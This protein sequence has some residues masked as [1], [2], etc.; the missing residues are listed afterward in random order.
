MK[1]TDALKI[2]NKGKTKW[3]FPRKGSVDHGKVLKIQ[4]KPVVKVKNAVKKVSK[5]K[6]DVKKIDK[7]VE[8]LK[9]ISKKPKSISNKVFIKDVVKAESKTPEFVKVSRNSISKKNSKA[10]RI[11][12]F[13]KNKLITNK[14]TLDNRV[15]FSK[16]LQSRL[17]SINNTDCLDSKIFK[18][19]KKGY[20]IKNIIDLVKQIGTKS[21]Y[22]LIYLSNIK[23]SLGGFSIVSKV[24]APTRDNLQEIK[25]MRK[26][27]D[28]L[29]L[30]KKTKH[31]AIVHKHAVCKRNSLVN[32]DGNKIIMPNQFKLVSINELAH[33]DLKTLIFDRKVA[34]NDELMLN[35]LYQVFISIATFQNIVGYVHNDA[36]YGNF[37]YQINNEKGYYEYEFNGKKYYLKAC[38]YNMI[39]YD[40]GL[41]KDIDTLA[42][43]K[44]HENKIIIDYCRIINAFLTKT[45]GWGEYYDAPTKKC[46]SK[47]QLIQKKLMDIIYKIE[48]VK[49]TP[50]DIFK[51]ILNDALIPFAPL[52]MFME[53]KP[54]NATI[55]NKTPYKID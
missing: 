14:Y 37:L 44:Q 39:I 55:I 21:V 17:K 48:Q 46:E 1:Y 43:L 8:V 32:Y 41:S 45:Y 42:K 53:N 10:K 27:T 50:K 6:K 36:H 18:D 31:F 2:Y 35:I 47:V 5:T 12:R 28:K 25:L 33:G 4:G 38:G 40:F 49:K 34:L 3:C 24:M 9:N 26:I 52:N 30:T 54:A 22:G 16:Y 29:L 7:K 15:K 51:Y 20:T 13:L 19:G 11:Q 23:E